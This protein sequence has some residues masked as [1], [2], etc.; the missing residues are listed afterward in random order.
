[1]HASSSI[2][3]VAPQ[4]AEYWWYAALS[5]IVVCGVA[6]MCVLY[7]KSKETEVDSQTD[8]YTITEI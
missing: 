5:V 1:M 2:T 6:A 3:L 4:I 8:K 7:A